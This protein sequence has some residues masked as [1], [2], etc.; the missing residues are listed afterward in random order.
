VTTGVI[1]T[2]E[3]RVT[4]IIALDWVGSVEARGRLLTLQAAEKTVKR[5]IIWTK[6]KK[7]RPQLWFPFILKRSVGVAALLKSSPMIQP[8]DSSS[9]IQV[10]PKG[11]EEKE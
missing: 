7:K 3:A 4:V 9:K 5:M 6:N 1:E 11:H 8:A 2:G 10:T